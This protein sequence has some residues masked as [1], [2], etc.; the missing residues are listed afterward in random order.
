M[1][2]IEIWIFYKWRQKYLPKDSEQGKK[3]F[4]F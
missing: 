2:A 3:M 4:P 1:Y